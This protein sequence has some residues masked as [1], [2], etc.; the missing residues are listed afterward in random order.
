MQ[1]ALVRWRGTFSCAEAVQEAYRKTRQVAA[2]CSRALVRWKGR[3]TTP[4]ELSWP[5]E[6]GRFQFSA[7]RPQQVSGAGARLG[8]AC[9]CQG[10]LVLGVFWG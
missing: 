8:L 10:V 4:R 5:S 2:A 6:L 3:A 7:A 9:V 1:Q